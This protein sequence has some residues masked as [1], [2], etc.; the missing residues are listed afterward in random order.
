MKTELDILNACVGRNGI[1]AD[2]VRYA[3]QCWTR[4]FSLALSPIADR[5][6]G[7]TAAAERHLRSLA[8]R[9]SVDGS[10]PILFLD[11][12]MGHAR[13]LA[14]KLYRTVRDRRVSFMLRR[15]LAGDLGRLT[16]GTRDSEL[17]FAYTALRMHGPLDRNPYRKE[18]LQAISYIENNLCDARGL[19]LGCDWRDTMDEELGRQPLLSNNAVWYGV[20]MRA[21]RE[22][23][24]NQVLEALEAR[25]CGLLGDY[26]G[27]ERPDPLGIA[28][29]VLEGLI[30]PSMQ[31]AAL[32]ALS[33]VDSPHGV[34][35]RCRHNAY[36]AEEREVIDRT[37][38][39]V[40]WPFVVGY[41]VKACRMTWSGRAFA[42]EQAAKLRALGF[43]EWYDPATGKGYGSPLQGWSAALRLAVL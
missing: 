24:A 36:S 8:E 6:T 26:P 29:G 17:H 14:Q 15:Y 27:A 22:S 20:L 35:I 12:P 18:I 19:L 33:S 2:P 23:Q 41:V 9:Q 3:G 13:F 21:G 32:E 11:G 7:G 34:T 39:V 4:D 10:I 30:G 16:P 1:W 31:N 37:D 5:L 43:A 38:G 40:V 25:S 28:L 42:E